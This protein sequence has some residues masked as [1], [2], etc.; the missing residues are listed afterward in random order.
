MNR[1]GSSLTVSE[2]LLGPS[3]WL[4]FLFL[5]VWMCLGV[6][7][8]AQIRKAEDHGRTGY[9]LTG[10]HA[11]AKCESCHINGVFKGTPRDCASCHTSGASHARS[12]VVKQANHLP[13]QNSCDTCHITRAFS[14][15]RFSHSGVQAGTC[16]NCHN[17]IYTN[18]KPQGHI[19]TQASCDT[20]HRPSGWRPAAAF[21]HANVTPGTCATCHNGTTATGKHAMHIPVAGASTCDNCHRPTGWRPT[22]W[23]HSQLVVSGQCATCHSGAYPPADGPV[24]NH[25]PYKSVTGI[26]ATNCD[27]CHKGYGSW[28]TG[29]LHSSVSVSSQCATCHTGSYLG[30]VG[31]PATATHASVTGNCESCHKSTAS[32]VTSG[33]PDHSL[34]NTATNCGA[35]HNGTVATG[36]PS[37]HM[38]IGNA[39]CGT[40]HN[41]T[42]WRPT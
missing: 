36:R 31:K 4:S 5:L 18:G 39:T 14:G 34:F 20:C 33:K 21:D 10:A 1:S 35:C 32:W 7:A 29:M 41:V 38:P 24:V 27:S 25:I 30:A 22:L 9:A 23:N 17:G 11:T 40:C 8:H 28:A 37:T 2:R 15:A 16:T 3:P 42:G 6:S 19:S 12:N 26:T 13:T